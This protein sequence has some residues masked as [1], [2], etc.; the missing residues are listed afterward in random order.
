MQK[1]NTGSLQ[2][3]MMFGEKMVKEDEMLKELKQIRD[4]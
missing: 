1:F 4:Y 3:R 2:F